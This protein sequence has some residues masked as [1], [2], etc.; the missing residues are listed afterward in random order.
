MSA[1]IDASRLA[2]AATLTYAIGY[3]ICSLFVAIAPESASQIASQI[4]HIDFS[5]IQRHV[6][7]GGFATGLVCGGII[8]YI[9]IWA[10]AAIYNGLA[11]SD[12]RQGRSIPFSP[13]NPLAGPK[14]GL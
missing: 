5:G 8:V 7:W 12:A 9:G 1:R 11:R 4:T 3:V 14:E 2:L 13:S 6:D 10:T